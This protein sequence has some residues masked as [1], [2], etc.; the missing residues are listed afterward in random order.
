MTEPVDLVLALD[1]ERRHLIADD[2]R[3]SEK[4]RPWEREEN[5]DRWAVLWSRAKYHGFCAGWN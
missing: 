3:L 2:L 1:A 4:L 5:Q